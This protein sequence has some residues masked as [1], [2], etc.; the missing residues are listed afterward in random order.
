[1][2]VNVGGEDRGFVS[3]ILRKAFPPLL[4]IP[5][6]SSQPSPGNGSYSLNLPVNKLRQWILH[7]DISHLKINYE[8]GKSL[9]KKANVFLAFYYCR[10]LRKICLFYIITDLFWK[11]ERLNFAKYRSCSFP[12]PG[13]YPENVQRD[14]CNPTVNAR[15]QVRK[16]TVRGIWLHWQKKKIPS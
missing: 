5:D 3:F 15:K 6:F 4:W 2:Q 7:C 8:K 11:S 14:H 1:M 16:S 13:H 10:L 12:L 9:H